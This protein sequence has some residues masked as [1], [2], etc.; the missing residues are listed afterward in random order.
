MPTGLFHTVLEGDSYWA[1]LK[2]SFQDRKGIMGPDGVVV[3]SVKLNMGSSNIWDI[4]I[5][6]RQ[7]HIPRQWFT[8]LDYPVEVEVL[9]E[10]GLFATLKSGTDPL[11]DFHLEY[12]GISYL[13]K[14]VSKVKRV[15]ELQFEGETLARVHSEGIMPNHTFV[16]VQKELPTPVIGLLFPMFSGFFNTRTP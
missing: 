15:M 16:D 8:A 1:R 14:D 5:A 11:Q 10:Q 7:L 12:Q 13:W 6:G 2:N 3:G 9:G 4:T